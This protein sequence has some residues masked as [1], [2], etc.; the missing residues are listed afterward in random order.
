MTRQQSLKALIEKSGL[1]QK[2]FA[3][4]H[5]VT[6]QSVYNW[7]SGKENIK[8]STLETIAKNEGYHLSIEFKLEKI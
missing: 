5:S 2:Q 8:L 6:R 1:N 3:E 4:K 7:L